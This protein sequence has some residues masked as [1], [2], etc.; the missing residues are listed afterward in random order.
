M[1]L[2]PEQWYALR[3]DSDFWSEGC[4]WRS[5]IQDAA[6]RV[7]LTDQDIWDIT[8]GFRRLEARGYSA[9]D[10]YREMFRHAAPYEDNVLQLDARKAGDAPLVSRLDLAA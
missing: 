2:T 9:S 6:I 7:G 8:K 3:Q 5:D 4:L 1:M 10:A